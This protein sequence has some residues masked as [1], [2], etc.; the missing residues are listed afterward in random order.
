MNIKNIVLTSLVT[1]IMLVSNGYAGVNKLPVDRYSSKYDQH[2]IKYTKRYFSMGLDWRYIKAQSI[3]ESAL[4][5]NAR[6]PVGAMGL[7][8]LMPKT[9]A[10]IKASIPI[11]TNPFDTKWNVSA[12]V[13]YDRKLYMQWKSP[14]PEKDRL[15]FMFASYNAGLSNPLKAQKLCLAAG[16]KECNLWHNVRKYA[17]NVNTWKHHETLGY[18]DKIMKL[19]GQ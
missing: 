3:A 14:R 10:E 1:A 9:Y 12:G 6:S 17:P 18:V 16:G 8:Q 15:A 5:P 13:Y 2:F 11:G 4:N 7:L 19:M